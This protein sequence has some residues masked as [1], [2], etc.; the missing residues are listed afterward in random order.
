V[1]AFDQPRAKATPASQPLLDALHPAAIPLVIVP[2]KMQQA[3][4]REHPQLSQL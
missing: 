3:V 1:R 4:Q 2:E